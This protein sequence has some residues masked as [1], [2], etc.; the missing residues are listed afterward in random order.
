VTFVLRK[1]VRGRWKVVKVVRVRAP[2]GG[3]VGAK[4]PIGR[5]GTYRIS[6]KAVSSETGKASRTV[7][8]QLTVKAKKAKRG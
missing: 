1:K 2:S 4:L 8:K 3:T 7:V 6:I 5:A